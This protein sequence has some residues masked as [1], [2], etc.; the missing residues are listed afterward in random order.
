MKALGAQDWLAIPANDPSFEA[1]GAGS[2]RTIA[3]QGFL[4]CLAANEIFIRQGE[5]SDAL[6]VILSGKVKAFTRDGDGRARDLDI[7]G[8]GDYV[9][10]MALDA[11]LRAASVVAL[12]TTTCAVVPYKT[13]RAF[14][15]DHPDFALHLI[16]KLIKR[17]RVAMRL[18]G[19][20]AF[21][22]VRQ[23]VA[24]LLERLAS[25][26][27]KPRGA[28]NM[29]DIAELVGASHEMIANVFE[30]FTAEGYINASGGRIT[31]LK[32]FARR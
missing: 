32:S 30:V 29:H 22:D 21:M 15:A 9:G 19:G 20:R 13:L 31:I 2:L 17:T 12:E 18:G 27:E 1:L 14:L 5:P 28:L 11:G 23:R 24:E 25:G 26:E 6:Y 16:E 10:E 3:E 7:H 4:R 8:P